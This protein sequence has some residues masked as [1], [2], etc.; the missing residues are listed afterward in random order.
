MRQV[1]VISGVSGCGKSTYIQDVILG[2]V[3]DGPITSWKFT[4]SHVVVSADDYFLAM[5]GEYR[6]D[7]SKLSLAHGKCFRDF[8]ESM[9]DDISLVVVDN[10][11]TT[12]EEISPYI[13]GAQAF[14]YDVELRTLD[15]SEVPPGE[16]SEPHVW[17]EAVLNKLAARNAHGVGKQTIM[18]QSMRIS[19]RK[20]PPWWK[21]TYIPAKV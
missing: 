17:F 12:V 7:P 20:L 14:G 6:F 3:K 4:G 19:L 13:L 21:C 11:C 1:I 5:N 16:E 10:T 15:I 8:I 2:R 18:A 9:Q